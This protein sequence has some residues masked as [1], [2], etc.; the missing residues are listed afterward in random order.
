MILN[1]CKLTTINWKYL[2][3]TLSKENFDYIR[4]PVYEK[5]GILIKGYLR[6]NKNKTSLSDILI[7]SLF[8]PNK[9]YKIS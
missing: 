3:D 8:D 5:I 4:A 7:L 2:D 6:Y 1:E 9:A